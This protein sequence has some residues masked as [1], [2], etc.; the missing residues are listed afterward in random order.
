MRFFAPGFLKSDAL[1]PLPGRAACRRHAPRS[2]LSD[3]GFQKPCGGCFE[4]GAFLVLP[5]AKKTAQRQEKMFS[6]GKFHSKTDD[7]ELC[8]VVVGS[9]SVFL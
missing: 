8:D 5:L 2:D 9:E 1:L 6:S 3:S 4:S 7:K